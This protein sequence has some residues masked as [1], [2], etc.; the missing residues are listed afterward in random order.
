MGNR[1]DDLVSG[2]PIELSDYHSGQCC[3]VV[4]ALAYILQGYRFDFQS[5]TYTWLQI[6]FSALVGAY[7]GHS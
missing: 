2:Q 5:R 1:L 4:K 3:S 7:V 6:L